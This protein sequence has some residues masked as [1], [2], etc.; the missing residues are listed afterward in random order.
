MSY[1]IDTQ[2]APDI[3]KLSVKETLTQ[4][5]R[6]EILAVVATQL[7]VRQVTRVMIDLTRAD[8]NP[9]EPMVGAWELVN[10]MKTLGIDETVRFAFLYDDAEEHR[11]YF[12]N[13]AQMDGLNL[14]YFRDYIDA[15]VWLHDELSHS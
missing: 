5:L 1:T 12:E 2:S 9:K 13:L 15:H 3:L 11:K 6:K 8:F 14:R 7:K 10:Y 4:A